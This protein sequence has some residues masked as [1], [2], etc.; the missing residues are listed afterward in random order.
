[1]DVQQKWKG[2]RKQCIARFGIELV[3]TIMVTR[4]KV[5]GGVPITVEQAIVRFI[6]S[7]LCANFM[8]GFFKE[9]RKI[10]FGS[11]AAPP[12]GE[13]TR[14]PLAFGSCKEVCH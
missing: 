5:T 1:M 4:P 12:R 2:A 14:T 10:V 9:L 7:I 6:F 3:G 8:F 13:W 11:A